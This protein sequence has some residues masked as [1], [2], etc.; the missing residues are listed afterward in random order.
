MMFK[1]VINLCR[2][3]SL[4]NRPFVPLNVA[5]R[6][7]PFAGRNDVSKIKAQ[8]MRDPPWRESLHGCRVIH[9]AGIHALFTLDAILLHMRLYVFGCHVN[10]L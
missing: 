3:A 10:H 5:Q 7:K 6:L 4:I 9:Y 2:M 8:R 1:A